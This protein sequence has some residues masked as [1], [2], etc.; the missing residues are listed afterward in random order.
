[1]TRDQ[2]KPGARVCRPGLPVI[3][4]IT[5]AHYDIEYPGDDY[6]RVQWLEDPDQMGDTLLPDEQYSLEELELVEPPRRTRAGDRHRG[7]LR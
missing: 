2:A 3:G 4:M 7:R 5:W 1:M 6:V